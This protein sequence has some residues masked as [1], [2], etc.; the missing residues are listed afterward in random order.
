[1]LVLAIAAGQRS[2]PTQR[3]PI[4]LGKARLD[5][6]CHTLCVG[7]FRV[8][9][10]SIVSESRLPSKTASR[11]SSSWPARTTTTCTTDSDRIGPTS[12]WSD[13]GALRVSYWHWP[14]SA[15]TPVY[16]QHPVDA[17]LLSTSVARPAGNRPS[18]F[19]IRG[20]LSSMFLHVHVR[21]HPKDEI[22]KQHRILQARSPR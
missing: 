13:I 17:N 11:H 8:P 22:L 18:A 7:A 2:S 9:M 6:L 12:Y 19:A 16:F 4:Q 3:R 21:G 1:M 5:G 20:G 14:H 10:R 15:P